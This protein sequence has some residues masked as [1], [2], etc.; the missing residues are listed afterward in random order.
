MANTK[1][2]FLDSLVTQ[3][4]DLS[5]VKV[6]TRQLLSTS[7]TRENTPYVGIIS[8]LEQILVEDTTNIRY[9]LEVEIFI[10]T[11]Q[12]DNAIEPLIDTIKNLIYAPIDLGDNVLLT[13]VLAT[14]PVDITNQDK[15][16]SATIALEII[17]YSTKGAF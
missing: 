11:K 13:R 5:G 4:N 6:A 10:I 15:F 17:Y 14:E 8:G 3:M 16:S 12:Q 2:T 7:K 9:A 1:Q